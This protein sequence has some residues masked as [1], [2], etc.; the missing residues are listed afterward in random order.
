MGWVWGRGRQGG[1]GDIVAMGQGNRVV[2]W[3][4]GG[5]VGAGQIQGGVGMGCPIHPPAH[6]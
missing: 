2:D 6:L 5:M 4:G 3:G 1:G